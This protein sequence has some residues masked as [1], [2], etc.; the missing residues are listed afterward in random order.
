LTT[1]HNPRA[2]GL[3]FGDKTIGVAVADPLGITAQ[4]VAVIRREDPAAM[5]PSIAKLR[6]MIAEYGV[7][8]IILGYPK[9]LDNTEGDRCRK[10]LAFKE[11]LEKSL[12]GVSVTLWDER[13][14]TVAVERVMLRAD[15]SRERRA[16]VV[17]M[18]AAVFILQGYLDWLH[19]KKNR[20]K[21]NTAITLKKRRDC[22]MGNFGDEE[23]DDELDD[24]E[25]DDL[26]G[27]DT[28]IITLTDEDGGEKDYAVI[29]AL[30]YQGAN[31]VLLVPSENFEDDEADAIIL[32]EVPTEDE[33]ESTYED[34]TDDEFEAVSGLFRERE[35]DDYDYE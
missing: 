12:P 32:K 34:V 4:G 2:I 33:D 3:D 16:R 26:D 6:G 22:L 23:L 24:F 7:T 11:R 19:A 13:L 31:Y 5:R 10:T 1:A 18:A 20:N 15:V 14:S 17:D 27:E 30:E 29:D 9:R 8:D 25:L 21:D 28:D 35:N